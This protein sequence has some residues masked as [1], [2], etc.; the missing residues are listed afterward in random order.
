MNY[1]EWCQKV[2]TAFFEESQRNL[3]VRDNGIYPETLEKIIWGDE[4]YAIKAKHLEDKTQYVID[5]VFID[6]KDAG[7]AKEDGR[8]NVF[9]LT[10]NG[11]MAVPDFPALYQ[12]ICVQEL[13]AVQANTLEILAE[14]T[15]K[16]GEQY[17]HV[18]DCD[19]GEVI[20]RLR[21]LG[22]EFA[23]LSEGDVYEEI[24]DLRHRGLVFCELGDYLEEVRINF[25]GL[26]WVKKRSDMVDH[27]EIDLLVQDGET[28]NVDLKRELYLD[29]PD[30]KAEFIKDIIGLANT[31]VTGPRCLVIG[32][33]E[34]AGTA[35]IPVGN[36]W[37][38]SLN[39]ERMEQIISHY[40]EPHVDIRYTLSKYRGGIAAIIEVLRDARDLPYKVKQKLGDKGTKKRID[41]GDVFVRHGT[42]TVRASE[43]EI[44]DLIEESDRAK[45]R[46]R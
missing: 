22:G 21:E 11:K 9:T 31:K 28:T 18:F 23:G 13:S 8:S 46:E 33:D 29:T 44:Q 17:A 12:S 20:G 26:V 25:A 6:L 5:D 34:K 38:E 24:T 2:L 4:R 14:L 36:P 41:V 7:L 3:H 27:R 30:Q 32:I 40:A 45:A 43:A 35:H 10:R 1:I 19:C 42:L 39:L 16:D 37:H 15:T